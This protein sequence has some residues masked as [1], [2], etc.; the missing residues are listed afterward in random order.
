MLIKN[1]RL[2]DVDE[3]AELTWSAETQSRLNAIC[4]ENPAREC[5]HQETSTLGWAPVL[6]N[7]EDCLIEVGASKAYLLRAMWH[8]RVLPPAVVK[9]A[10]KDRIAEIE[11]VSGEKVKGKR[12]RDM[13]DEIRLELLPKAF[14]KTETAL[15]LIL[16]ERQ[17]IWFD[18]AAAKKCEDI[19][20]QIRKQLGSLPV[21]PSEWSSEVPL[22]SWATHDSAMPSGLN[23]GG[24]ILLAHLE[25]GVTSKITIR[26][27]DLGD[28]DIQS[29]IP[30]REIKEMALT[31][32]EH[33][34]F[35]ISDEGVLKGIRF[36]EDIRSQHS[37]EEG[38]EGQLFLVVRT[39]S[40]VLDLVT[41]P[42]A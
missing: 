16:P 5:Q 32:V 34:D 30:P 31:A 29:L 42:A 9:K 41:E 33:A 2:Y 10:L 20:S 38:I 14:Q 12:K 23:L 36:A 6:E 11:Q 25:D 37:D 7:Q 28:D 22:K 1:L 4:E 24:D 40:E 13:E 15:V 26:K 18:Q 35:R 21:H 8:K 3:K 27:E 19:L 17:Q 39:L